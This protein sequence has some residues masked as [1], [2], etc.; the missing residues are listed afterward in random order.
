MKI[1]SVNIME[2]SDDKKTI[3]FRRNNVVKILYE[4]SGMSKECIGRIIFI[5]SNRV[6]IDASKEYKSDIR[7]ILYDDIDLIKLIKRE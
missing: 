1:Q 5:D 6:E 3:Q 7:T 4:M 2:V